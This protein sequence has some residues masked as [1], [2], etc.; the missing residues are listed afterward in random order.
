MRHSDLGK[1]NDTNREGK[2][3]MFRAENWRRLADHHSQAL[4]FT[5]HGLGRVAQLPGAAI[6][7]NRKV[8]QS[9]FI[10]IYNRF[11]WVITKPVHAID[12]RIRPVRPVVIKYS[13]VA[14]AQMLRSLEKDSFVTNNKTCWTRP[15]IIL[16][17]SPL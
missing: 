9:T 7:S 16:S 13:D 5:W 12:V 1:G 17:I 2:Q 10:F 8:S 14:N 6:I 3:D 15:P 11:W 4:G